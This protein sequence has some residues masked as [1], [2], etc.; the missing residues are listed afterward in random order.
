M[1][2]LRHIYGSTAPSCVNSPTALLEAAALDIKGT[3]FSHSCQSVL[4]YA[5]GVWF[6]TIRCR[7][8]F[9]TPASC[10]CDWIGRCMQEHRPWPHLQRM[11]FMWCW[12]HF[13]LWQWCFATFEVFLL[14]VATQVM[15]LP[16]GSHCGFLSTFNSSCGLHQQLLTGQITHP[17][18]CTSIGTQRPHLSCRP[19]SPDQQTVLHD[20]VELF[21]RLERAFL[22]W[23]NT[24]CISSVCV[25]MPT[26]A[27]K[28]NPTE[29]R[30]D[31]VKALWQVRTTFQEMAAIVGSGGDIVGL[32]LLAASPQEWRFRTQRLRGMVFSIQLFAG[33][34]LYGMWM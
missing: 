34:A 33:K 19:R 26:S 3:T 1:Q 5:E 27:K 2:D 20:I 16:A 12:L 31:A 6:A 24:C 4:D 29:Q 18:I 7:R 21:Q 17:A 11:L 14:I 15:G 10:F 23:E 25:N 13:S 9:G 8:R 22:W 32:L 28:C 30:L